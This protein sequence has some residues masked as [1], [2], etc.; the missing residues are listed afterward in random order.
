MEDLE[1]KQHAPD[2]ARREEDCADH[3]VPCFT[4]GWAGH[5]VLPQKIGTAPA[6]PYNVADGG[7]WKKLHPLSGKLI[8]DIEVFPN[9]CV[10]EAG[11]AM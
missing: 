7:W 10:A 3:I 2:N 4:L 5:M 1:Q 11:R 6:L 8:A 9:N